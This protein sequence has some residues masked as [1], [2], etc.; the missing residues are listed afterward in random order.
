M[1]RKARDLTIFKLSLLPALFRFS[2]TALFS[3]A[4]R[5]VSLFSLIMIHIYLSSFP[6]M[7]S[8]D[9]HSLTK[10]NGGCGSGREGGIFFLHLVR[11]IYY[12]QPNVYTVLFTLFSNIKNDLIS[13]PVF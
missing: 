12:I 11:L 10:R 8:S 5:E 6:K 9:G 4:T 1:P 2:P 7:Y 3:K 13:L